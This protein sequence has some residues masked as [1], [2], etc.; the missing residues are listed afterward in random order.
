MQ[1]TEYHSQST[2]YTGDAAQSLKLTR[3]QYK[4]GFVYKAE[5]DLLSLP[6]QLRP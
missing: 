6:H 5:R 4:K 3:Q 1:Y 2:W